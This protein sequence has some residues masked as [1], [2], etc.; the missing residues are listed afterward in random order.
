MKGEG[1]FKFPAIN[2]GG[3]YEH[4]IFVWESLKT[5]SFASD[6]NSANAWKFKHLNTGFKILFGNIL[7]LDKQKWILRNFGSKIFSLIRKV[8]LPVI[9]DSFGKKIQ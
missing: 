5:E 9:S 7:D 6:L 4:L 8:F 1:E 3:K 2:Y